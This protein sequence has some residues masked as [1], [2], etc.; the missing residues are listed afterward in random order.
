MIKC[1]EI[2]LEEAKQRFNRFTIKQ[3][4]QLKLDGSRGIYI[5]GELFSE[6]QISQNAKFPQ[7]L[8]D[9]KGINA[10]LDGEICL[11]ENSNV[12]ELNT[13]INRNRAKY[14]VF[15][16]LE[17]N[18]EDLRALPL[19]KR[20]TKLFELVAILRSKSITIPKEWENFKEAWDY[21]VENK[22]E[23]LVIKDLYSTYPKVDMFKEMRSKNWIKLKNWLETKEKIVGFEEG[24]VKGA[25][26]LE[27]GSRISTLKP[28]V[29][30]VYLDFKDI[31]PVYAEFHYLNKTSDN[32]YFQP[33]L[34]R[35]LDEKGTILWG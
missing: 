14:Y 28:E 15:D 12:F 33:V 1:E 25:F 8:S 7:I 16:I 11:G 26:V 20:R 21:V 13:K 29:S 10:V 5:N 24:S 4:F 27:N 19:F 32:A 3:I 23:G 18:G 31:K 6:R 34:H 2:K 30:Q 9:L 35:L 22:L 17:L